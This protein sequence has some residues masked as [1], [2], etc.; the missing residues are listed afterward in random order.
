MKKFGKILLKILPYVLIVV[1]FFTGIF[2]GNGV[3]DQ[4]VR[5]IKNLLEK[6]KAYYYFE[7]G[8]VVDIISSSILD[9]YST[10]YTREEYKKIQDGAKGYTDGIGIRVDTE[11]NKIVL[12]LGNSPCD[13]AGVKSG[14]VVKK[15][16][17]NNVEFTENHTQVLN[18]LNIG[19][20]LNL[21]I[22]YNG[23]EITYN[24]V[25]S[26]YRQTFVKY[27]D[28]SGEYSFRGTNGIN[29]EKISSL[30]DIDD[31]SV[32]YLQYTS[33][34]G[35]DKGLEGSVGQ[36]RRALEEFK[37]NGKNKLILDLRNNGG[38][39]VDVLEEIASM[40][41]PAKNGTSQIIGISNDKHGKIEYF[42]SK[43]ITFEDYNIQ[44]L[45]V[46]A[47]GMSAS[48]SEV[49]IGAILDYATNYNGLQLNVLISNENKG[50]TSTYGKGIMQTTYLNFDGSAVKLTTAK[51]FL[52]L[53]NKCIH[54]VGFT[55][56]FDSRIKVVNENDILNYAIS[57]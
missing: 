20:S 12:V 56:D 24:I 5:A 37:N 45:V 51:L 42:K 48:A 19:Q 27:I 44:K 32:G 23:T 46:L 34:S 40:V 50:N 36:F 13:I 29:F 33:F 18:G 4:D 9:D 3:L 26:N 1:A 21:V 16:I 57:L 30:T 25:K 7:E 10:Y 22:D 55:E 31:T 52:P 15:V 11:T 17:V 28:S 39:Y 35:K 43:S 54:G 2:V 41:L 47:N 6:Y 38:G 49:L 53:T 14:G 8:N